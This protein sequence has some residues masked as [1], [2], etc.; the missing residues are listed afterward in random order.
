VKIFCKN[1]HIPPFP[2][3]LVSLSRHF[4]SLNKHEKEQ[5][6][7]ELHKQQGKTLKEIAKEVHMSFRDISRIIKTYDKKVRL[8][9]K[10]EH[11]NQSNQKI[12]KPSLSSRV[13]KLFS[14]GKTSTEVVIELDIPPEKVEKLWS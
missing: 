8:E 1:E 2:R 7:I 12:K 13:F 6:V 11:N 9:S 4:Q 10:K 14:D 3:I 5:K